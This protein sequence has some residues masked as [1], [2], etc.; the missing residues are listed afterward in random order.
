MLQTLYKTIV[1]PHLEYA[2]CIWN[3]LHN[4]DI[5]MVENVQRRAT[6][7]LPQLFEKSYEERLRVLGL[8]TLAYRRLRGDLI[9]TYKVMHEI[10]DVAKESLFELASP[11]SATRGH[12]FKIKKQRTRLKLREHSFSNRV[13][14]NWNDLPEDA[15][16]AATINC[17]KTAVDKA[18]AKKVNKYTYGVGRLWQHNV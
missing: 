14:N 7:I 2:N 18:L 9:Q 17:F 8:L 12:S 3:P 16:N 5:Q 4:K 10:N 15:V 1:R 11:T 13:V 6:K